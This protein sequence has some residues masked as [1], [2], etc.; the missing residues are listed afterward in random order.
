VG[1]ARTLREA[2]NM[3]YLSTQAAHDT[4]TVAGAIRDKVG[5]SGVKA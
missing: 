2:S 3:T 5:A 1:S 4:A